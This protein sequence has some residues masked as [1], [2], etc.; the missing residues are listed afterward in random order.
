MTKVGE[1]WP[2]NAST[3]EAPGEEAIEGTFHSVERRIAAQGAAG[4]FTL[5]PVYDTKLFD[6]I[7]K[8]LEVLT[9]V[10]VVLR[11]VSSPMTI[12]AYRFVEYGTGIRVWIYVDLLW[13]EGV[14]PWLIAQAAAL[15]QIQGGICTMLLPAGYRPTTSEYGSSALRPPIVAQ[16]SLWEDDSCI[17]RFFDLQAHVAQKYH[18]MGVWDSEISIEAG[19]PYIDQHFDNNWTTELRISSSSVL[20]RRSQWT[21]IE[22]YFGSPWYWADGK[23][24]PEAMIKERPDRNYD[25]RRYTFEPAPSWDNLHSLTLTDAGMRVYANLPGFV[26]MKT[27]LPQVQ[28]D[29]DEWVLISW[30]CENGGEYTSKETHRTIS[31]GQVRESFEGQQKIHYPTWESRHDESGSHQI[32]EK[33]PFSTEWVLTETYRTDVH[34]RR[35]DPNAVPP[36]PKSRGWF[37]RL[38]LRLNL[39]K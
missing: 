31:P 39:I 21:H 12:C 14:K 32:W 13:G 26:T 10:S 25:I 7:D 24:I 37:A 6:L 18:A 27:E 23:L 16:E 38:L 1:F 20:V 36:T 8:P 3:A 33:P 4:L 28:L 35:I 2:V 22:Q 9:G 29:P 30:A 34:G 17:N 19:Q 11:D 15:N 5:E